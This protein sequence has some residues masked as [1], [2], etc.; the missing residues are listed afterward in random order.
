MKQIAFVTLSCLLLVSVS[1]AQMHGGP[2]PDPCAALAK[3]FTKDAAFTATAKVVSAGKKKSDNVNMVMLFAVSGGNMRNEMDMTK[4]SGVRASDLEGMKQM[5]MDKMVILKVADKQAAYIVYPGLQSY[6]D[7]PTGRHG[8]TEGKVDKTELGKDTVENHACTKS[9]LT[10]TAKDGQTS[11]ALVW[12]AT[13]MKN[14]PIQYQTVD[15][16]QTT[17]TTFTDIKQ[18]KP[19]PSLFELPA[20]YKRYDNMQGMMMGNMQRMMQQQ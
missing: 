4:M 12:E 7:M 18:G 5:G 19:D 11:E 20:S 10:F 8:S 13:D 6:C 1:S 9:K 14:F 16:G 3:F 17:T 2:P 15:E